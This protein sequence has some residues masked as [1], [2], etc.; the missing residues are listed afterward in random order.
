MIKTV[1]ME[2]SEQ[3]REATR[4]LCPIKSHLSCKVQLKCAFFYEAFLSP[5]DS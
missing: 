3:R 4:L 1:S 2:G 5:Q